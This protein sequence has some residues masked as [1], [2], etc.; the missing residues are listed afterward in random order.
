MT[1][2]KRIIILSSV[3]LS[4][5]ALAIGFMPKTGILARVTAD[6]GYTCPLPG[7]FVEIDDVI[8]EA[9]YAWGDT[10]NTYKFR[11]TVT[12]RVGDVAY[13]QR[14]NQTDKYLYGLRVTGVNTYA[15]SLAV[16]N[17]VD[18]SGGKVKLYQ[19][20]PTF[21][22]KAST[23]AQVVYATNPTG[24]DPVIYDD[25]PNLLANCQQ[26]SYYNSSNAI[27]S[28]I[29]AS[30][31]LLQIRGLHRYDTETLPNDEE[32]KTNYMCKDA[33][34]N[35]INVTAPSSLGFANIFNQA[36]GLNYTLTVTGIFKI[37][38][39]N[40]N[41]LQILDLVDNHDAVLVET[42]INVVTSSRTAKFVYRT[43]S[44][45]GNLQ[46]TIYNINGYNDVP[47]VEVADFYNKA[48]YT[49]LLRGSSYVV[50]KQSA[51]TTHEYKYHNSYFDFTVNS[52]T[53]TIAIV[54]DSSHLAFEEQGMYNGLEILADGDE[55]MKYCQINTSSSHVYGNSNYYSF[56]L[57]KYNLDI[58]EDK[59]HDQYVPLQAMTLIFNDSVGYATR[60]NGQDL[61]I[62]FALIDDTFW[63]E[64][65][66]GSTVSSEYAQYNY[67]CLCLA[68]EDI[69]GLCEVR[70]VQNETADAL[71][72]RLGYK[73]NLLSTNLNTYEIALMQFAGE[74]FFEGHSG[75]MLD[76]YGRVSNDY[77][78]PANK[79]SSTNFH[80]YYGTK[81]FYYNDR[82]DQFYGTHGSAISDARSASGKGPG[83]TFSGDTAIII[84][85]GF[86]KQSGGEGTYSE[87][88]LP[89]LDDFTYEELHE[90]D[91]PLMFR[92]AF[93]EIDAKGNINNVVIDLTNNGGGR[94]D[95]LIY[96]E[97]Y[98]TSDPVHTSYNRLTDTVYDVHYKMD[99]NYDGVFDS[100]D[101][102]E[103][104]Y[105]FYLMTSQQSFSCGNYL[106]ATAKAKGYA[107][108]IGEQ[109][110]GGT[111]CVG[112]LSTAYG[113]LLR[114]SSNHFLGY[115]SG[116]QFHDVEEGIPVD[117]SYNWEDFYDDAEINAFIHSL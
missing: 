85:D 1:N 19:G 84:F 94:N 101:T 99:I 22:L 92:K 93:N 56:N 54:S 69:Y 51:S 41:S 88:W 90:F 113:D 114:S 95:A 64:S 3:T 89:Y 97:A 21:E 24:Y 39:D 4:V 11:G 67:S 46:F 27:I 28:R 111:C 30:N 53:D 10:N 78:C 116:G 29:Y 16:G 23:N 43:T 34:D 20:V 59:D 107:T 72:T 17:V 44:G 71:I 70:G 100:N 35:I 60:Y 15:N 14:V 57:A 87:D 115:W 31:R 86:E 75:A 38:D 61:Y 52:D 25:V 62:N 112:Y 106:P 66:F 103:G 58:V 55:D 49:K 79:N 76:N 36:D 105:N 98:M 77:L 37:H 47:Y 83:V 102:Y 68:L 65:T 32:G 45:T 80:N 6:P 108:L 40:A 42:D 7:S 12:R 50:T 18:F 9:Y 117:Q 13:V 2:K 63:N 82:G 8:T 48:V 110:G 33:N 26:S 109:S 81:L 74:W 91:T 104:R 73:N 96:L 5:A